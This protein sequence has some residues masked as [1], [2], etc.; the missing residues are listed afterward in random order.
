MK[1]NDPLK[2][3]VTLQDALRKEKVSLEARLAR[4]NEVLEGTA[5]H[6]IAGAN[7]R[8][9]RRAGNSMSLNEAVRRVT[10]NR[11]LPKREILKSVHR[12]GYRF[13]AK[14]PM[15]SLNTLLYSRDNF[16][17]ENGKFSPKK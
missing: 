7:G 9:G 11:P 14:D 3:F 8:T 16:K 4:I 1:R 2:Q 13:A 10:R 12:L 17:N 6:A 15:N 5:G